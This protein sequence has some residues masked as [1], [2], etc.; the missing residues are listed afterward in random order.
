MGNRNSSKLDITL[1][2]LLLS[3][4]ERISDR[5]SLPDSLVEDFVST[6]M[7][8]VKE[9]KKLLSDVESGVDFEN[10]IKIIE[11]LFKTLRE[12]HRTL[13]S[14]QNN[15]AVIFK[16]FVENDYHNIMLELVDALKRVSDQI[17]ENQ[18]TVIKQLINVDR[19]L[20]I[21]RRRIDKV[22]LYVEKMD[23]QR[24]WSHS[25]KLLKWKRY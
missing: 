8:I 19:R 14:N 15:I 7:E 13:A 2:K 25:S 4:L 23:N 10:R 9:N 1:L 3:S 24:S 5:Y 6:F 12:D 21:L 16:N 17:R 18:R 20:E 22:Q 11:E